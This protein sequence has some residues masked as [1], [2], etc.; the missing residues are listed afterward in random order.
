MKID[1]EEIRAE[2]AQTRRQL[3]ITEAFINLCDEMNGKQEPK[4]ER[5]ASPQR[6]KPHDYAADSPVG[7]MEQALATIP[8]PFTSLQ[9]R[10]HART[11]HPKADLS[12][13]A[14]F[15]KRRL[16]RKLLTGTLSP[17]GATTYARA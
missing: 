14:V 16:D 17:D 6:Q 3:E 9:F 8:C 15:L 11:I 2:A 10:A 5:K 4:P 1:L 12:N 13:M 7:I